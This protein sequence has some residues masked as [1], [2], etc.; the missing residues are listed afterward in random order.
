M[1]AA[2]I[3]GS[4]FQKSKGVQETIADA[5]LLQMQWYSVSGLCGFL[6]STL[7]PP[8]LAGPISMEC[9]TVC[10]KYHIQAGC[11]QIL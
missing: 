11:P 8:R 3:L 2:N 7:R 9:H 5:A 10:K 6:F 4:C 1:P